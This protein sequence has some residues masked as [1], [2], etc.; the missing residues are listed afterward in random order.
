MR[1]IAAG[2]Y[3][4]LLSP[5][6]TRLVRGLPA[7]RDVEL[8]LHVPVVGTTVAAFMAP[9]DT[10]PATLRA[11]DSLAVLPGDPVAAVEEMQRRRDELGLSYFIFG[12]DVAET[13]APVVAELAGR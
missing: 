4:T 9:P 12:A 3:S 1:N 7:T 2:G 11:A 8:A 6:V 5:D 13:L 10:D